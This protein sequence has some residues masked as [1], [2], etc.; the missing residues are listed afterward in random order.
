M[1]S[2]K[3]N[4]IAI[5]GNK[6]DNR[7]P[8]TARRRRRPVRQ[9]R[10]GKKTGKDNS[11]HHFQQLVDFFLFETKP[12]HT[13][14]TA[15]L[16]RAGKQVVKREHPLEPLIHLVDDKGVGGRGSHMGRTASVATATALRGLGPSKKGDETAQK[17]LAMFTNPKEHA[18]YLTSPRYAHTPYCAK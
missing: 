15:D 18:D 9:R 2:E 17:M 6:P 16:P 8:R 3:L 12:F 4:T 11:F 1:N 13:S 5:H 7:S 10:T 14:F